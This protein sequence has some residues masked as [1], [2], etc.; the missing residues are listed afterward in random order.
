MLEFIQL[1][2][3]RYQAIIAGLKENDPQIALFQQRFEQLIFTEAFIKKGILLES[4][5]NTPLQI[6]IIGPT[7]AGKSSITNLITN[8]KIAS[9]S[10]LAGYT[11]HPQGFCHKVSLQDCSALQSYFGRFQQL[12]LDE[13]NREKHDCYSLTEANVDSTLLPP[14][15]FWDTPDFDS[16]DSADYKEGVIKTIALADIV[17]LVVSKEKY[18]D[19]SVWKMMSTIESFHQTTLICVNKLAEGT[20]DLIINS[21]RD[22]WHQARE[23]EFPDVIPLLFQKKIGMPIWPEIENDRF[24]QLQT[25]VSQ[26]NHFDYQHSLLNKYWYG[27]L[28]PVVAEHEAL[29]LWK[30]LVDENIKQAIEEYQRDFLNHPQYY[31]TFQKA[32]VELLE[33]L[34]IP[35]IS[36][37]LTKTRRILTWPARKIFG[38]G[39]KVSRP[40]SQEQSLL[41]QIGEH[42]LISLSDQL[43]EKIDS[44]NIQNKWWK[45]SYLLLRQ[46]KNTVQQDYQTAVNNY[47]TTFQQDVEATA[48]RLY[49]K[50]SEHPIILNSLRATRLTTDVAVMALVIE[51]GGIGIHDL[52]I[53][54]ALLS[55]TSLLA[56]SAVGSSMGKVEAELKQHQLE[57]VKQDLFIASLQKTLYSLPEQLSDKSRFNISPELLKKAEQQRKEKKHGIRIL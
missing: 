39:K 9:V 22:K 55:M 27:W 34:E 36:G 44:D 29:K 53:T 19:Q 45:N 11:V 3:Q 20:E 6:A 54:P 26:K 24:F 1:L 13:L 49:N 41:N 30:A 18:A 5:P 38:I 56:E 21:L 47:C 16:I 43:L 15:V 51:T 35:G 37:V 4:A 7:Q 33:L 52:I 2:T 42:V 14:C 25:T 28:E 40:K 23:D 32:L 57:T 50:L 31:D 17:I 8:N 10:P 48:N 12:S 46:Q